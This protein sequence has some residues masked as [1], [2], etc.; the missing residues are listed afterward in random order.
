MMKDYILV[1]HE[2]GHA[3]EMFVARFWDERWRTQELQEEGCFGAL[4]QW[5][6][7]RFMQTIVPD[8]KARPLDILDCGCGLGEW[9]LMFRAQ[10]HRTVGI[11]IAPNTVRRLRERY[12][13]SFKLCDFRRIEW[14][15]DSFDLIINWGGIEHFEEGPVSAIKEAWRVLRPGGWYVATTPCHNVRLFF[16]DAVMGRSNSPRYPLDTYRF[17][18]YR[19]T[20][21]EIEGYFLACG[22]QDARSRKLHGAQGV[23]RSLQLELGWLGRR[24]PIGVRSTLVTGFGFLLRP[25]LGHMVICAGR[26]TPV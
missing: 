19:F 7:Y 24:L 11:D 17:Y 4:R 5:E 12:G 2:Q 16:L 15:E 22:F 13:D 10:G 8:F 23:H 21:S 6:E 3:E 9:T 14:P 1:S 25:L 26:K 20:Q 18:Q